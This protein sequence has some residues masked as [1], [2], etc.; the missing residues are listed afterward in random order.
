MIHSKL[1]FPGRRQVESVK[2]IDKGE[3]SSMVVLG[4]MLD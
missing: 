1:K 2:G 4:D 3:G